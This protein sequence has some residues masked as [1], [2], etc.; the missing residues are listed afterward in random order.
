[1]GDNPNDLLD[2]RD[3][4]A[5]KLAAIVPITIENKRD[6]DEYLIHP[7]TACTWCTGK[8]A[9][10]LETVPDPSNE[11]Y[12][13]VIR[14]DKDRL[15]ASPAASWAACSQLRDVDSRKEIQN[16]DL[17]TVHF[18]DLVNEI[19]T[20]LRFCPATRA[21]GSSCNAH[22]VLSAWRRF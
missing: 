2:Q 3:L 7:S 6:P 17:M 14:P 13:K 10:P 4:L 20:G 22:Y 5:G 21:G 19:R 15:E 12:L 1:M 11:G 8:L 9:T 18:A 16:L